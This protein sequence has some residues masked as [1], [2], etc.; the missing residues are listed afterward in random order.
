MNNAFFT[1]HRHDD[2]EYWSND[3]GMLFGRG[4]ME[5]LDKCL[6]QQ[7]KNMEVNYDEQFELLKS[8]PY[9]QGNDDKHLEQLST[10]QEVEL[11]RNA[12][13]MENFNRAYKSSRTFRK[14]VLNNRFG[15][16]LKM[17]AY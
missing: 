11:E 13:D 9:N 12:K 10:E 6:K 17:S 7:F 2:L 14:K 3:N 15:K 4:F 8:Q 5:E 16:Q 1:Y